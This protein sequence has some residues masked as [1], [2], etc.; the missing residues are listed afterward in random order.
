MPIARRRQKL[1]AIEPEPKG[2]RVGAVYRQL[3]DLIVRGRLAPGSRIVE[4]EIAARLHVSRTPVRS[5]LH[6]LLQEGYVVAGDAGRR[7]RLTVAP[8]TK[9]DGAELFN[10]VAEI[11]GLAGRYAARLEPGARGRLAAELRAVNADLR[12]AAESDRPDPMRWFELDAAFHEWYVEAAGQ[13][14]IR[15]LH[16]YLKPQVDRY[17]RVYTSVLT[18]T[19]LISAAEHDRIVD[20]IEGGNPDAAQA[21]IQ[22]NWRN[23]AQRLSRLIEHLGERGSW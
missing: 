6:R 20:G 10:I 8:L 22:T 16:E 4:V 14:R 3:R 13:P 12:R 23:A 17:A 7:A 2:T 9:E 18:D 15:A 21:A 11:E 5:A 19:I 1:A